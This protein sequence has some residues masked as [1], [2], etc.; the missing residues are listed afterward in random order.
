MKFS[1]VYDHHNAEAEWSR[2]DL[3]EWLTDIFVAPGITVDEGCTGQIRTHI[4]RELEKEGWATNVKIDQELNLT[5]TAMKDDLAFQLQTGNMSRAPYD[6]LKL[7]YL[8]HAG[9]IQAAALA[10]PTKSCADIIG[11]NV[12]NAE[13]MCNELRVFDRIITVPILVVAFD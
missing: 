3:S 2:R 8:Y 13:R 11:S 9:K 4:Q 5:V 6:M 7:Q 12:A 1:F 10:M